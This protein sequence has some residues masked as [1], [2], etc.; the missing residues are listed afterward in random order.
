MELTNRIQLFGLSIYLP[1][2]KALIL[3]DI[4]IGYEES[5][6]KQGILLP[7]VF[8]KHL[9][10]K[11]RNLI[12]ELDVDMVIINGDLKHEFGT[13]SKTEWRHTIRFL[14]LFKGKKVILIKGNHDA[15]LDPIAQDRDILL[16]DE[17]ILDDIQLVHGDIIK[18]IPQGVN[19]VII[20]HEHPAITLIGD[21]RSE[22]YKCFLIGTH[23]SDKS[24]TLIA[25]PS[26]NEI[27]EGTNILNE[28]ILSPYLR[29]SLNDFRV[30]VYGKE[31]FDFGKIKDIKGKLKK[32]K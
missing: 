18:P 26:Y 17:Y 10:E 31:L 4:H 13:I 9:Y 27:T 11:T 32:V 1:Q 19:T 7:R 8:F 28:S 23:K 24:K 12:K 3:S 16:V 29:Q 25:M 22:T 20:G 15:T 6:N 14:D 2:H 5:L 30:I 21:N